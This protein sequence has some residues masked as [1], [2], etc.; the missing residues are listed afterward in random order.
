[1]SRVFVL[2][3]VNVDLQRASVRM[4]NVR[5]MKASLGMIASVV[6]AQPVNIQQLAFSFVFSLIPASNGF[7]R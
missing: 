1:M 2:L 6:R 4:L 5:W 3:R 7:R